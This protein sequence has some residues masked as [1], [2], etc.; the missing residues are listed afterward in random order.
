MTRSMRDL[1]L[2][3]AIPTYRLRDVPQ[4]VEAYDA[5]FSAN[6]HMVKLMVFDDSSP[7]TQ[8]KYYSLL[9]QTR[10]SNELYYVGP[11]EKETFIQLV[12]KR[13]NDRR[14]EPLVRNLFRPSYGGNRNFT[15]IY[16]LGELLVSSDD[17]MRPHALIEDSPESLSKAEIC[18]G[19]LVKPKTAGFSNKSFDILSSFY[20]VLGQT[21][22]N[23]PGNFLLG[24]YVTDTAMDLETNATLGLSRENSLFLKP[25]RVF[26]NAIVKIAQTFRTGTNDIDAVDFV[27]LFLQNE[28][29]VN[30]NDLNDYYALVNFR[31][32]VTN[33]NWRIDCGV[34]GYDNEFGLPPFFPTRLRFED[35]IFRLWIRRSGVVAA[36]VDSA[37]FHT[38]SNYMRNPPA[39]EIFNEEISNLLKRKIKDSMQRTGDLGIEFG[40]DGEVTIEDSTFILDRIQALH[41]RAKAAAVAT[42]DPKRKLGIAFFAESLQKSFYGFDS[43]FFQQNVARMVDDV[44]SQFKGSL[45]LWPTLIEICYYAKNK[46]PFPQVRVSNK[47]FGRS[48]KRSFLLPKTL[49]KDV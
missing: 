16:T 29:Q 35:Y 38:K 20:D 48:R 9:E 42:K 4:T 27:D 15:L 13:L 37:Q 47:V 32:V 11:R 24:E 31:P 18:R 23:L 12:N 21:V 14:L 36:H 39:S 49:P 10:T 45:D 30:I 7:A 2:T 22:H 3:F 19:K 28:D 41:K 8:N 25:G 33:K 26:P 46:K 40:Y 44:I 5:N 43:D 17:D 1:P 34:A 6:G